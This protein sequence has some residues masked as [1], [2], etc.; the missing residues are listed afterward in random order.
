MQKEENFKQRSTLKINDAKSLNTQTNLNVLSK[1]VAS[2]GLWLLLVGK[3]EPDDQG[4]CKVPGDDLGYPLRYTV[5]DL[6]KLVLTVEG[7]YNL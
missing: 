3:C 2:W 7:R 6:Q 4:S 1:I 5:L